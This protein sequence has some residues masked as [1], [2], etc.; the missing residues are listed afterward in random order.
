[1]MDVLKCNARAQDWKSCARTGLTATAGLVLALLWFSGCDSSE[2]SAPASR[3]S[4]GVD[5]HPPV[6]KAASILPNPLTRSG[7]L[8]VRVEA[9]DLDANTLSF[10][11][12]WLA[13]G[14][15]IEGQTQASLPPELLK[16]GDQ[17]AVE[18]TPFD[19]IVA[20]APFRSAPASVVNTA[21]IVSQV[22]VDFDHQ[23]QGRRLLA[24]VDVA[25]PDHDSVSLSYRWRK[26]NTVLKEGDDNSLDLAG[27]TTAD[28]ILLDVTVSDGAPDG[29]VTRT[30]QYALNNTAPT[31]VSK[32]LS[33]PT[34]TQYDYLVQAT[35]A[36]GDPIAYAL[37]VAPPGMTIDATTGQIHWGVTPEMGG[38]HRIRVIAKDTWGGFATQEFDLSLTA[39]AK[40]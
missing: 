6:V 29:T 20:G 31:I 13:N 5:N 37:E 7:P 40:S 25:D 39:P 24:K 23:A 17:V 38:S 12:R 33:A 34:G 19:G 10:R 8:T 11:Y 36:D 32:P 26:G 35:D 30:E 15:I 22:A 4:S 27:M 2:E 16:R 14:Q 28:L 1:M 3:A 18:V 21:P 9:Q